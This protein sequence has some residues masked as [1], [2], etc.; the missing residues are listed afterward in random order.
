MARDD[1][2]DSAARGERLVLGRRSAADLVEGTRREW[3]A[4]TGWGDYALGTTSG[5]AT[6]RYHGLLV[7]ACRAPIGRRMLVPFIDAE[8]V[9][10]KRR[11]ALASRRWADGSVEPDGHRQIAGFALEDG[12]PA[13]TFELGAARLERRYVMLREERAIAVVW[14]LVD[15]PEPVVLEARVF[16]EHRGQHQL[17]PDATWLPTVAT[18]STRGTRAR[19]T[20]PANRFAAD[21][22]IL[23][24]AVEGGAL[25][26]AANWWR[27]HLLVKER[28]RGYDAIGSSCHALTATMTLAPGD[29]RALVVGLDASIATMAVDGGTIVAAERTR[30]A[31]LAA[32]AA[33][34]DPSLRALAISADHFVVR[35]RRRDGAEG[36]SIIAGFPW[37]EDWGRD[38]ML[39]LPGLLLATGRA[40]EAKSVVSTFLEHLSGGLLP[41]RFPDEALEPEHHSADAPL[42]AIRAALL[43]WRASGDDAWLSGEL[44]GLLS[45]VDHY[46]RGTRHGIGVAADGLVQAGAPGLQLTW[47]DA[48]VGDLVVTPRIGKPIELSALWIAGLEGLAAAIEALGLADRRDP[49]T[50]RDLATRARAAFAR[51]WNPDTQ[52]F[53]DLLDGPA[54]P[55]ALDGGDKVRP[56]QLFAL[57]AMDGLDRD[58]SIRAL[59]RIADDLAT[60]LAVR[61]LAPLDPAYRGR[62]EG[63]QRTRDLAYHNGT[64]W[65]FLAGLRLLAE[66]R[67]D[68]ERGR[69]LAVRMLEDLEGQLRDGGLGS[70][71]EIV[72]GDA[73]HDPRGCPM[74]AWS[75]GCLLEG[76]VA[77][78]VATP[79]DPEPGQA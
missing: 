27:R 5:L 66:L 28:A 38:A 48:K 32:R 76:L 9:V 23:H 71:A 73:P 1:S 17:D 58:R 33:D 4:T 3:L 21:E 2:H 50:L 26:P 11:I 15:A 10:G 74:Q 24:A 31:T 39:A 42:L 67:V 36:R 47:M 44:D 54:A 29:T 13:W 25:A 59:A 41:N 79:P 37:F 49:R 70:V 55:D 64:A 18:E 46:A 78:G 35:R 77:A 65:P 68:R 69:R 63:D 56:N 12:I 30:R 19:I 72:D 51:F 34:G 62:Y 6:R 52:C 8:A 20:L 16:V 7:G 22:T 45:I 53:R 61:T 60:P 40:D 43:A 75:V 14:T 57:A